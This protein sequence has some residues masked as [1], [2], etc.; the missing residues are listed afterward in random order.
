M[1]FAYF[2]LK[3]MPFNKE[4]D[5]C[6]F[7][8]SYDLKESLGRLNYIKQHRGIFLLTGEPGGGKTSVLRS[9]VDQLNPQSHECHYTPL[10]T[11]SRNEVYRQLNGLLRLNPA[12]SKSKMFE[13]IQAAIWDK[14]R[15]QGITPCVILDEAHLMEVQTLQELILL[16]NF[17]MDSKVPFILI[18]A[19]QP[20]LRELLGR[21]ALEPLNQRIGLR[22]HIAGLGFDECRP[23]I[24]HHLKRAGRKEPLFD[25]NCFEM[26][27][28]LSQGLPRKIGNLCKNAMS[29]AQLKGL[30]KIDSEI[31][32]VASNGL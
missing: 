15:H 21:R 30:Q 9:F 22:Y 2:G 18:L 3:F 32:H 29:Y 16:T 27:H 26:I 5:S 13:Q 20:D 28:Q 6:D 8:Q 31:I 7:F 11:V 1:D 25:D 4:Q 17:K 24:E 14:Y 19:G 12:M 23:Y 10:A